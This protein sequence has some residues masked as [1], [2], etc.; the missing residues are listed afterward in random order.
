[1]FHDLVKYVPTS[2]TV[3]ILIKVGEEK[4]TVIMSKSL[5]DFF[6]YKKSNIPQLMINLTKHLHV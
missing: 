2:K 6:F 5:I 4:K 1:M 3:I